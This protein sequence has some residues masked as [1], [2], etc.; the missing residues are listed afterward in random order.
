MLA[1][2]SYKDINM[3]MLDR[4]SNQWHADRV[5][6]DLRMRLERSYC[7]QLC[8]F[9]RTSMQSLRILPGWRWEGAGCRRTAGGIPL[10]G[11]HAR[12]SEG[13]SKGRD[14]HLSGRAV[15]AARGLRQGSLLWRLPA[16]RLCLCG[17]LLSGCS[18]RPS[19]CIQMDRN[20]SAAI[21]GKGRSCV[22]MSHKPRPAVRW[23]THLLPAK[24]QGSQA[25]TQAGHQGAACMS[26]ACWDV[27]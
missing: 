18:D 25:P 23:R 5:L 2:L 21:D 20:P 10:L 15:L 13:I 3:C 24:L 11:L 12:R 27:K 14:A 26:R 9:M 19:T 1:K 22:Q 8:N 6:Q 16:G 7:P 4:L 17:S